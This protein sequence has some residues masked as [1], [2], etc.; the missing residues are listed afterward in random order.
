MKKR[1]RNSK[2]H[3]GWWHLK[4]GCEVVLGSACRFV[5][6]LKGNHFWDPFDLPLSIRLSLCPIQHTFDAVIDHSGNLSLSKSLW[7][8]LL[9]LHLPPLSLSLSPSGWSS[10]RSFIP[11]FLSLILPSLYHY[12]HSLPSSLPP[13]VLPTLIDSVGMGLGK[14]LYLLTV[15]GLFEWVNLSVYLIWGSHIPSAYHASIRA[16]WNSSVCMLYNE[17]SSSG[18]FISVIQSGSIWIVKCPQTT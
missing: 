2:L 11:L 1:E 12:H 16:D 7:T 5:S 3:N 6:N 10:T 14:Q 15:A 8:S 4:A 9:S 13:L 18:L 17:Y